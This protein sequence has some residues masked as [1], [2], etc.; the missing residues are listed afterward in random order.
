MVALRAP[1][2]QDFGSFAIRMASLIRKETVMAQD[3]RARANAQHTAPTKSRNIHED[4]PFSNERGLLYVWDDSEAS[5][6]SS[7][8]ECGSSFLAEEA[9]GGCPLCGSDLFVPVAAERADY[10]REVDLTEPCARR[11]GK[12][13]A[14]GT[15]E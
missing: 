9:M 14:T 4:A 5:S 12:E 15:E 11:T 3:T 13:G 6:V 10:S 8:A 7:C 2:S 1:G